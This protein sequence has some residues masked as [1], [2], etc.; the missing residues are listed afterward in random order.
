MTRHMAV[1]RHLARPAIEIRGERLTKERLCRRNSVVTAKEKVD[2]LSL[3]VDRSI[4]VMPFASNGNVRLVDAPRST[5]GS[6]ESVPALFI[7]R[8]VP[9]YPS[10]DC[11]NP[12]PPTPRHTVDLD[13]V[14]PRRDRESVARHRATS[15][16]RSCLS[17]PN[18]R[19]HCRPTDPA[20]VGGLPLAAIDRTNQEGLRLA[21]YA[22]HRSVRP[23]RNGRTI[24]QCSA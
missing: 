19:C 17:P 22:G 3:L 2:R 7:F 16:S 5:D 9:G 10:Q 11:A 6:R 4:E 24:L 23:S 20:A 21:R 8:H 13:L 18:D 12:L 15:A 14:G 1:Q